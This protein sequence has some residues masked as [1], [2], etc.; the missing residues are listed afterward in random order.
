M[1]H[2]LSQLIMYQGVK[3]DPVLQQIAAVIEA[4]EALAAALPQADALASGGALPQPES[5]TAGGALAKTALSLP[6]SAECD[7]LRSLLFDQIYVILE[8]GTRYG[9]DRNLWQNYLSFLLVNDENPLA[10]VSERQAVRAASAARFAIA[11][12][13]QLMALMHYDFSR[14]EQLL[15]LDCLSELCRYTALEKPEKSYFKESSVRIQALSRALD[16]AETPSAF[17]EQ[18]QL[19]YRDFGVG[20]LGLNKAF[21]LDE[22]GQLQ[23]IH[24]MESVRLSDLVGYEAQ[25]QQLRDN[26]LAFLEG[27][28]ANNVLLYGDAGTGKST[29]VKAI[30]NE[31]YERGLRM[32]EI[33][34]HQFESL[35]AVIARVKNRN[36]KFIIFMDDLS[37]EDFEVEYKYLKAVIE[38]GVETRPDNILIYATSNRRHLIKESWRD[39]NDMEH[40]GDIHRSDTMEEKLSLVDRFGLNILYSRPDFDAYHDIVRKLA[41]D[42]GIDMPDEALIR[43]A[44]TWS[45]RKGGYSGRIAQQFVN[46]L[47]AP[48]Q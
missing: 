28:R 41:A 17:F 22:G 24:N 25:K 7:R 13:T 6:D 4:A 15:Q 19:F 1:K 42:A 33:Y 43:T 26:T 21:R 8:Y 38:G 31:F 44:N 3:R 39:R 10:M 40:D 5:L 48:G 37:F 14:L 45:V 30:V 11:D 47:S 20:M 12:C 46:S 18:L 23:A 16:E 2:F 35:S 9:F 27:R 29:S 36:Y 32:I 34:K